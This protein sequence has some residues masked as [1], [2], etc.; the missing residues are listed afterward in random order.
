MKVQLEILS[1][2]LSCK[3]NQNNFKKFW[4]TFDIVDKRFAA[5]AVETPTNILM[6]LANEL[7][8]SIRCHL[9]SNTS[10]PASILAKLA[11]ETEWIRSGVAGNPSTPRD[12]IVKLFNDISP[13]VRNAATKN[14]SVMQEMFVNPS[15]SKQYN[16]KFGILKQC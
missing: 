3:A 12:I 8:Y 13:M 15:T 11:S 4:D 1:S 2:L 9:A 7:D 5:K 16:L 14:T 10:T 6:I